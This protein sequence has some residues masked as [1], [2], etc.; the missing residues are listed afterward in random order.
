MSRLYKLAL[1]Q[2]AFDDLYKEFEDSFN[3]D[4]QEAVLNGKDMIFPPVLMGKLPSDV[5]KICEEFNFNFSRGYLWASML[6]LRRLLPLSVVRKFQKLGRE[7]NI[8]N[9][10]DYLETKNLL[11]K[12]EPCLKEK[13]VYKELLN[14]KILTDSSQHSYTFSPELSDVQGAAIKIRVLLEDLFS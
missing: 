6:L 11:G 3:L 4:R 9:G 1:I 13:R 12:A 7:V 10:D 2:P 14:Y 5:Q 8:K